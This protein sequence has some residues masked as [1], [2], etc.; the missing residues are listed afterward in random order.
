M[1]CPACRQLIQEQAP[2][3]PQ[4]GFDLTRAQ[5]HFGAAP[6]FTGEITDLA[7]VLSDGD[8]KLIR[9]ALQK[10]EA[11]FPQLRFAAV[12]TRVPPQMPMRAHAFWLFNQPGMNSPMDKGGACRLVLIAVDA[13]ERR[14]ACMVGYGLEPFVGQEALDRIMTAALPALQEQD[15]ACAITDALDHAA[16]ELAAISRRIPEAFGLRDVQGDEFDGGEVFAY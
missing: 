11:R 10:H 2:A 7:G 3:C 4:C 6:H 14:V 16:T 12:V 1:L 15:Y 5:R 8:K 9:E 13:D